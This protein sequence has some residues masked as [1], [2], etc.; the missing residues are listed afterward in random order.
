MVLQISI[1][2]GSTRRIR[3]TFDGGG[4]IRTSDPVSRGRSDQVA[5]QGHMREI[6]DLCLGNRGSSWDRWCSV[7]VAVHGARADLG[8]IRLPG[9]M[10][11]SRRDA[12]TL[13]PGA[14]ARTTTSRLPACSARTTTAAPGAG[15]APGAR[16]GRRNDLDV[17]HEIRWERV[18]KRLGDGPS[19]SACYVAKHVKTAGNVNRRTARFP[20]T[21]R[22]WF[23][24]PP[25][26]WFPSSAFGA[27]RPDIATGLA[28]NRF[29]ASVFNLTILN[30]K[31]RL[32]CRNVNA[33][34][35]LKP[36]H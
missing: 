25:I 8:R 13:P 30:V 5:A 33:C 29:C 14:E 15:S 7:N 9:L 12:A 17:V 20:H 31:S 35:L 11:S 1:F 16:T 3:E 34:S 2:S 27:P 10:T 24:P 21:S 22:Y 23:P 18:L 6:F 36:R 4:R 19:P 28:A 26:P 32:T